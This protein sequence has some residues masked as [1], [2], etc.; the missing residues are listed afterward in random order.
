MLFVDK[1]SELCALVCHVHLLLCIFVS[2]YIRKW[3]II[4]V[5]YTF[6]IITVNIAY[7]DV[8][9]IQDKFRLT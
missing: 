8:N 7:Q 4:H 9:N 3:F 5:I 6:Y 1:C 2:L